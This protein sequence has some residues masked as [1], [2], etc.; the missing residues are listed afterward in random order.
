MPA[1]SLIVLL[2]KMPFDITWR[3]AG[4]V[5]VNVNAALSLVVLLFGYQVSA[6]CGGVDV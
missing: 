5:T 3:S 1:V 6:P 4:T 2:T